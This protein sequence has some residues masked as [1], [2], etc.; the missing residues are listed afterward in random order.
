[1]SRG[2]EARLLVPLAVAA[3]PPRAGARGAQGTAGAACVPLDRARAAGAE[4]AVVQPL[5]GGHVAL[6]RDDRD[7][8]CST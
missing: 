1:M 6:G 5:G 4:S 8:L 3:A 2:C 7:G